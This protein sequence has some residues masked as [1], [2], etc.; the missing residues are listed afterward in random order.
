MR[1]FP[2]AIQFNGLRPISG[3]QSSIEPER[4]TSGAMARSVATA[5]RTRII[6]MSAHKDT[7]HPHATST[8]PRR[9]PSSEARRRSYLAHVT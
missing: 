7:R 3:Q 1:P 2:F 5:T 4:P 9:T 6:I 8:T